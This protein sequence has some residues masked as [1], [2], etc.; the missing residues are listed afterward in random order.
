MKHQQETSM[1]STP[2]VL[3]NSMEHDAPLPQEQRMRMETKHSGV[4]SRQTQS[5]PLPSSHVH[6][7]QSELQL[8]EDMES[9]ERRDLNHPTCITPMI[10]RILAL[11]FQT[12]VEAAIEKDHCID[13]EALFPIQPDIKM[14]RI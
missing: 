8:C 4:T 12:N 1:F 3:F 5:I 11:L 7:T 14:K 9:A 2:F 13:I 6:R 10:L